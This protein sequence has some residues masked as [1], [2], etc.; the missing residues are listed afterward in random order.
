MRRS[1]SIAGPVVLAMEQRVLFSSYSITALCSLKTD[2]NETGSDTNMVLMRKGIC[3]ERRCWA[4]NQIR[5]R[6]P[7]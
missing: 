1:T 5:A 2:I 7:K 6:S 4:V 3:L